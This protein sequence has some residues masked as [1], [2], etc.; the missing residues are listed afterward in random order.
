MNI[1]MDVCCLNRC[2][3]DQR[4]ARVRLE[5]EAVAIVF[6]RVD[7]GIDRWLVSP[8]VEQEISRTP[9]PLR[10]ERVRVFIEKASDGIPWTEEAK[11][12]GRQLAERGIPA[13]DALH[14]A[15][16]ET[17]G[18]DIFLTTDDVLLRRAA[19]LDPPLRVR[20]DNPAR[21]ITEVL[22]S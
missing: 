10:R 20:V 19:A 18:C 22:G 6:E 15:A 1:Y 7:A 16:A 8:V 5:T 11:T 13:M 12:L 9:D 21:W 4:Q 3:D 17:G 14:L 2:F